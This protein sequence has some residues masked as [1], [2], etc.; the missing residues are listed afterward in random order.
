MAENSKADKATIVVSID[1]PANTTGISSKLGPVPDAAFEN[2]ATAEPREG[3][4]VSQ[5]VLERI[6][7]I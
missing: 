4:K 2:D 3:L 1:K 7:K 5:A 6:A